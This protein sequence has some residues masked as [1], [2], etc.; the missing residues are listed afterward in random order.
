M[1]L[2]LLIFCPI[3]VICLSRLLYI[4]KCTREYF[5]TDSNTMRPD[6]Q[7]AVGSGFILF[8]AKANIHVVRK[9]VRQQTTIV[10]YDKNSQYSPTCSWT[11]A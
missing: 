8:A 9:Q 3:Y 4:F 11:A 5:T 1:T 7:G 10:V 2:I 6:G